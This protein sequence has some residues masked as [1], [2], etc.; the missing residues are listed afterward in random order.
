MHLT[1]D[2]HKVIPLVDVDQFAFNISFLR[3]TYLAVLINSD[4]KYVLND[5]QM[6]NE[7]TKARTNERTGGRTDGWMEKGRKEGI[8]NKIE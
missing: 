8:G 4:V 1:I 3:N 6:N 7:R 2:H 5:G